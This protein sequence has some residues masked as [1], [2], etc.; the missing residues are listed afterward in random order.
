M[1]DGIYSQHPLI[2]HNLIKA[3]ILDYINVNQEWP[4][5]KHSLIKAC[6]IDYMNVNQ[7]WH[8][9]IDNWIV[10]EIRVVYCLVLNMYNYQPFG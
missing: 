1:T 6:I 9:N 7:E 10:T 5:I 3:C 2:K 8:I 4:L